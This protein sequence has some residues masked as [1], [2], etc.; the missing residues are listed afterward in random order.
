MI[1]KLTQLACLCLCFL[2][3]WLLARAD[4]QRVLYTA[5]N[6]VDGTIVCD[7][8]T[9]P[10]RPLKLGLGLGVLFALVL[11]LLS[12]MLILR[13]NVIAGA[14]S[15]ITAVGFM[16]V[17]HAR[18]EVDERE[19]RLQEQREVKRCRPMKEQEYLKASRSVL[20]GE[21]A[22]EVILTVLMGAAIAMTFV[23]VAMLAHGVVEVLPF[24]L[25]TALVDIAFVKV[26]KSRREKRAFTG[27]LQEWLLVW[28]LKAAALAAVVFLYTYA[29]SNMN[30]AIAGL[31]SDR[32]W[33]P[34]FVCA[35]ALVTMLRQL[36][37]ASVSWT[38]RC[39]YWL[40]VALCVAGAV[41]MLVVHEHLIYYGVAALQ[42]VLLLA[43]MYE[44]I[45]HY[46]DYVSRPV[47]YFGRK[48]V[49][50]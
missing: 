17:N 29:D 44:Q 46:N 18:R 42:M 1:I 20:G 13:A 26:F 14:C 31:V 30:T 34:P 27:V 6:G 15:L 8:P 16:M 3:V 45:L 37:P 43:T 39:C 11:M 24:G 7:T 23:L 2:P 28:F 22:A 4:G 32:A 21:I 25:L 49:R 9:E 5:I 19:K 10:K 36:P 40:S 33:L 48:G 50:V 12:G 41:L 38:S 47:P 35:F